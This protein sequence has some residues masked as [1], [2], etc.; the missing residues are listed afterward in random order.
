MVDSEFFDSWKKVDVPVWIQFCTQL[1]LQDV[2]WRVTGRGREDSPRAQ[3]GAEL[4]GDGSGAEGTQ[5]D[6]EVIQVRV[7][8][9]QQW[10][11]DC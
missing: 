4:V 1:V 9:F 6:T 7:I 3:D 2:L 10:K 11:A 8:V 5:V